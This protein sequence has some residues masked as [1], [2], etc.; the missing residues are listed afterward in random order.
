MEIP[1]W[2]ATRPLDRDDKPLLDNLFMALQP[3]ISELSFAGLFLFRQAHDYHLARVG[4]SVVLL[5]RGY[6][7]GSYFLPPLEGDVAGALDRLFGSGLELYGADEPFAARYLGGKGLLVTEDRD[8]SDYLYLREDLAHLP[9]NRFHKKRNRISYFTHRHAFGVEIFAPR[10]RA[11][12]LALLDAWYRMAEQGENRSLHLE[13][14]ATAEAL[15]MTADLGLEGVVIMVEGDV[16]A[17]AI[18]ERLNRDTAVCHFEKADLFMEGISQL[19]NR[20][21]SRLLFT[22]C[23]FINREQDLGEPGLR[24]AK[25]SYHPAGLVRKF[26]ARRSGT[27][28]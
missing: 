16:R 6:D 1:V 8:S 2:P 17:F 28:K 21:F 20:E 7:G 18:G 9:G 27:V 5:G 14:E 15:S 23:R 22:D 19:V 3:R 24:G 25:L 26:R 4:S 13:L 11:G 10:H 12:C